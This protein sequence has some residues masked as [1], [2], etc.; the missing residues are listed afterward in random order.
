MVIKGSD[1]P[2]LTIFGERN[3]SGLMLQNSPLSERGSTSVRKPAAFPVGPEAGLLAWYLQT[4][5][6]ASDLDEFVRRLGY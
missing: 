6:G 2:T 4:Q 5:Y 3:Y 1:G